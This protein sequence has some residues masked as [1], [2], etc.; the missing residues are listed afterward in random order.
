MQF[1]LPDEQ[2]AIRRTVREFGEAEIEP[3]ARD[4][5]AERNYPEESS[6]KPRGTTS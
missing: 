2:R 5:D 1:Q 3:V 4:H 6:R